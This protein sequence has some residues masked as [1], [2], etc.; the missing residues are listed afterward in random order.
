MELYEKLYEYR[1]NNN[2]SQEELAEKMEVSR[3]T[4]SK[5]E[6]GKTIP[7]LNKLIKLSEIYNVT[8]DELVK[9][10]IK[11]NGKEPKKLNIF[12]KK[13]KKIAKVLFIMLLVIILII[14]ILFILNIIRR[15]SIINEMAEEYKNV[16]QSVGETRSGLV[17][18]NTIK[19]EMANVEE[20]RRDCLYYVSGDG[21]RLVKITVYDDEFHKNAIEEVYIDLNKEIGM[22]HYAD[23]EKIN[24]R[25]FDKEIIKDYEFISPIKKVTESIN[26]Y[27]SFICEYVLYSEKELTFDFDNVFLKTTTNQGNIY[28]W[29]NES[30]G[31]SHSLNNISLL[32][33]GDEYLFLNFNKY[34][35]D[36]KDS[37]EQINIQ[38]QTNFSPIEE[39][40]TISNFD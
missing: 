22:D 6:S 15:K 11:L 27:Y 32:M 36:I 24:L 40:V 25:T 18:E 3:Q 29:T 39:E 31:G 1:K 35:E 34:K 12:N 10:N 16:Y 2:W 30:V 17:V 20:I 9:D 7:E 14:I 13:T 8:V 28:S 4:V 38:I 26:N 21:K 37:R 23:V 33:N 19:R 5:W